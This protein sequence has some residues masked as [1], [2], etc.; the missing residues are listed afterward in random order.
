MTD[1]GDATTP[2]SGAPPY[3]EESVRLR[4]LSKASLDKHV[5]DLRTQAA[6]DGF[7]QHAANVL[8]QAFAD[9]Q[10]DVADETVAD[11]HVHVAAKNVAAFHVADEIQRAG[12]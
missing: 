11:D 4:K 9:L 12:A 2:S 8:D 1:D 10:R 3:S 6:L 7:F 5:A